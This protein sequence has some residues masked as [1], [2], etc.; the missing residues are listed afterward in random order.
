MTAWASSKYTPGQFLGSTGANL[1]SAKEL[2]GTGNKAWA[3]KVSDIF[4]DNING[5]LGINQA[6]HTY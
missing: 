4:T 5:L 6:L 1:L 3:K 2:A